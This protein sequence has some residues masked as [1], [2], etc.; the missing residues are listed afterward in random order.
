M[1]IGL[2]R[3]IVVVLVVVRGGMGERRCKLL[4]PRATGSPF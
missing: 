3:V 2:V 1:L 4:S